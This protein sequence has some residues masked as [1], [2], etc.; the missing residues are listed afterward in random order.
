MKVESVTGEQDPGEAAAVLL[1]LRPRYSRED[2]LAHG[3]EPGCGELH[4]D[5]GVQRFGAHRVY[6]KNGFDITSHHFASA[7]L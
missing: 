3:G 4:L 5:S 1:Q 6:L 7:E 2:L